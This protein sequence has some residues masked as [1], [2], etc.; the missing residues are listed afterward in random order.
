VVVTL[1]AG[2]SAVRAKSTIY[3]L[4]VRSVL[5]SAVV[6]LFE[7]ALDTVLAARFRVVIPSDSIPHHP[8]SAVFS[9]EL[10]GSDSGGVRLA[11]NL[12]VAGG[13]EVIEGEAVVARERVDF[14]TVV[15]AIQNALAPSG[16]AG[17]S[18]A[19]VR[20]DGV[21]DSRVFMDGALYGTIPF[22]AFLVPGEHTVSVRGRRFLEHAFTVDVDAGDDTL[23]IV[24]L[25][26]LSRP[27]RIA[28]AFLGGV[29]GGGALYAHQIQKAMFAHY[30]DP[31]RTRHDFDRRYRDYRSAVVVRNLLT[32]VSM[33][34]FSTAL[35]LTFDI[36]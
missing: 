29:A 5:D 23:A 25:R 34:A 21:R 16:V 11:Y 3:R 10:T 18:L 24:D 20:I 6:E 14:A 27:Y 9:S 26:T 8:D 28:L 2:V 33:G 35:V 31:R 17:L 1:V 15:L 22:E 30:A 12:Y 36:P 19:R 4:P 32:A 13:D 7:T